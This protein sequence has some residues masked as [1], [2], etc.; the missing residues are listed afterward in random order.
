MVTISTIRIRGVIGTMIGA[1]AAIAM[2]VDHR[3]VETGQRIPVEDVIILVV[4]MGRLRVKVNIR[5]GVV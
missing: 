4:E 1:I 3:M 2:I 5:R